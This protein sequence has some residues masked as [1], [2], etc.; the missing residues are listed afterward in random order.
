MQKE[1]I[2]FLLTGSRSTL[3]AAFLKRL[4]EENNLRKQ[5]GELL[6]AWAEER[7]DLKLLEFILVN[8][9]ELSARLGEKQ[10]R[11]ALPLP[12]QPFTLPKAF[13]KPRTWRKGLR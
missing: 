3:K 11:S 5:I 10:E 4:A 6:E 12:A 8:G 9:A 1:I 2:D 13:N 7:A